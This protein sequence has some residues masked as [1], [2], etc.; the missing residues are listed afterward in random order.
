MDDNKAIAAILTVAYNAAFVRDTVA[1]ETVIH[2]YATFR[3][4]LHEQDKKEKPIPKSVR[5]LAETAME[6]A[7]KRAS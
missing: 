7:K 3:K 5:D 6:I 2:T 4:L 1:P